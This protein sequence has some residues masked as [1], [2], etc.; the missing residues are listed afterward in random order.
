MNE[1]IKIRQMDDQDAISVQNLIQDLANFEKCPN[2][3][4]TSYSDVQLSLSQGLIKGIVAI[5]LVEEVIGMAIFFPY[6]STW[7][8]KTLYLEDFYVR[9]E[10]RSH[11][12]GQLLFDEYINQAKAFGAKMLKW[13]VLDW[14]VEAKKFYLKNGARFFPGWENGIIKL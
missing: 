11:G 3:V 6:Y 4:N 2:E 8:G 9:P 14:N 7:N 1:Q 13:Q 12:V 10:Y 5:N